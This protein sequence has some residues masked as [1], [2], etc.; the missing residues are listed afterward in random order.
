MDAARREKRLVDPEPLQRPETVVDREGARRGIVEPAEQDE[1]DVG[2][3][4]ERFGDVQRIADDGHPDSG[5]QA[6]GEMR[7]R[8]AAIEEEGVAVLD[9]ARRLGADHRLGRRVLV[10]LAIEPVAAFGAGGDDIAAE[11][12]EV[13]GRRARCRG[14]PSSARRRAA[15]PP[16]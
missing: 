5:G 13:I 1:L 10:A 15:P 6:M 2:V 12:G 3:V 4:G 7:R 16:R 11:I 8:R 9:E 14:A